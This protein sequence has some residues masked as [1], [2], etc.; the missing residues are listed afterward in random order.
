MKFGLL[1]ATLLAA[2]GA[3][4]NLRPPSLSGVAR[5]GCR[6]DGLTAPE[7]REGSLSAVSLDAQPTWAHLRGGDKSWLSVLP[8]IVA[9]G[10]SVALKQERP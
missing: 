2:A 7:L 5:R 8:P 10:A 4:P 9:L 3:I 6:S 1:V